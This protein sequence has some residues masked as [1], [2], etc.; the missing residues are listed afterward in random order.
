MPAARLRVFALTSGNLTGAEQ[1]AAFV[2]AL[3]KMRRVARRPG[4]YIARVTRNG[5]VDIIED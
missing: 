4:P 5:A 1:G 3:G 2:R